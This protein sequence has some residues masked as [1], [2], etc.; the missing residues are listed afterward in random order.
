MKILLVANSFPWLKTN[1][2][3]LR[4][5]SV[6]HALARVGDV[7]VF[8]LVE[9][10]YLD[11]CS[12]VPE[13]PMRGFSAAAVPDRYFSGFDC[14]R[15]FTCPDVPAIF[16]RRD[17]S[18]ARESFRRWASSRYDLAW[19]HRADSYVALGSYIHAPAV[20]DL[21]D[22]EDVKLLRGLRADRSSW[23]WRG[24]LAAL[25]L[26]RE[27]LQWRRL[28]RQIAREVKT[29]VLCSSVDQ[30]RLGVKNVEIIPNTYARPLDAPDVYLSSSSTTIT[31]QG[32]LSYAPNLDACR[33]LVKN[34]AP[35]IRREVPDLEIRLVGEATPSV[36][37]LS[38]PS[39]VIVTDKV[40]DMAHELRR[41]QLVVVPLRY[42]SG[43]RIKI[44]EAFAYKRAVVSTKVGA[45]GIAATDGVHLLIRD[46]IEDFAAACVGLLHD[47]NW[48]SELAARGHELFLR[49]YVPEVLSERVASV[50]SHVAST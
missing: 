50:V 21:D 15:W 26:V 34:V 27:A 39:R 22:L 38:E 44:L 32:D 16:H 13:G 10:K 18:G 20:V 4:L 14:L 30:R 29:V 48:R 5:R 37:A 47:A 43:T 36:R 9:E 8:A 19:F 42:A 33:L 49:R 40:E 6:L 3:H 2:L 31:F 46:R 41:T 25:K 11:S 35:L 23:S 17:Y 24:G 45:E 7:D 28:E 1:G 12:T